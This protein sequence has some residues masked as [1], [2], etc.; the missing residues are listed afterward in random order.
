MSTHPGRELSHLPLRRRPLWSVLVMAGIL[1]G[2]SGLVAGV[3]TLI[4]ASASTLQSCGIAAM[5]VPGASGSCSGTISDTSGSSY[6]GL[7]D[8]TVA[9]YTSSMSA[10]HTVGS[11]V[12]TEALLDGQD[13]GLQ[14]SVIDTST[15]RKF[16]LGPASCYTDSTKSA[17]ASYPNAA[18]CESSSSSQAVASS[19]QNASFS[20]NFVIRWWF[21][22]KAGNPYQGS[23]ATVTLDATFTGATGGGVLAASTGPAGGVLG[24]STPSTGAALPETIS[25][26]LLAT[27]LLLVLAGVAVYRRR[28]GANAG[29]PP[30]LSS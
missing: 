5:V 11:G 2:A 9:I 8:V 10:G 12:G 27:G 22:W 26:A 24:A 30:T 28:Q 4:P 25:A 19:A 29:R 21:P 18:Y 3:A 16:A 17:P 13:T 20:N 1:I 7:V 14:V 6:N 23:A 15:R